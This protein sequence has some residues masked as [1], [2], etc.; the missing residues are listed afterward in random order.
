MEMNGRSCFLAKVSRSASRAISDLSS[1]TISHST[2]A[3][4]SPAARARSTVA[5][6]CPARLST[7]PVR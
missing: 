1:V 5:S 6:V 2:P 3:G 4:V 7:P